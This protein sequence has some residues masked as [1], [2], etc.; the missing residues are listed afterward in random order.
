MKKRGVVFF[1]AAV[2]LSPAEV[3]SDMVNTYPTKTACAKK[4][5]Q[6]I[7]NFCTNWCSEN[8]HGQAVAITNNSYGY[9]ECNLY[10]QTLDCIC[11]K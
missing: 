3:K 6:D 4:S 9:G 10:R 5:Y 2:L 7:K 8:K 1:M 11:T